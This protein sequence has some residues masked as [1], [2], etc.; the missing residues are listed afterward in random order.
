MSYKYSKSIV[1]VH[2]PYNTG[3]I[4]YNKLMHTRSLFFPH[5]K[6]ISFQLLAMSWPRNEACLLQTCTNKELYK[7][8][9]H[10]YCTE[11]GQ[12]QAL[13]GQKQV[14]CIEPKAS[15]NIEIYAIIHLFYILYYLNILQKYCTAV[16]VHAI[17]GTDV[18]VTLNCTT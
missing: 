16:L 3:T 6:K 8:C 14:F 11:G 5:M 4:L 2:L 15:F 13:F 18:L 12:K 17:C 7:Y 9:T 1:H 10:T